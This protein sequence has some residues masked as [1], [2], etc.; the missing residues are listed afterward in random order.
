M[1]LR[2]QE[3]TASLFHLVQLEQPRCRQQRLRNKNTRFA[4][5]FRLYCH[6]VQISTFRAVTGW[7]G[8]QKSNLWLTDSLRWW[9]CSSLF[10]L[11]DQERSE[12][13]K[14]NSAELR[15]QLPIKVITCCTC[16]F[17]SASICTVVIWS[18]PSFK[19]NLFKDGNCFSGLISWVLKQVEN[20]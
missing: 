1:K 2:A 15:A 20:F 4:H 10:Q 6:S 9:N 7:P 16:I 5:R 12:N 3:L 11:L 17:Y 18:F 19:K 13:L 8:V 14:I